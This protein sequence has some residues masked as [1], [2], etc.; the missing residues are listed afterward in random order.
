MA[1]LASSLLFV[2]YLD[3]GD[4]NL[5]GAGSGCEVVRSSGFVYFGVPYLNV[6]LVGML[7]Y[8]ILFV[9]SLGAPTVARLAR[10]RILAGIG[11][12]IALALVIAQ[13]VVIKAFCWLCG[14]VDA[15]A[16]AAAFVAVAASRAHAPQA[17]PLKPWAW[18][19]LLALVVG[20]PPLWHSVKPA[21]DVP[22]PIRELFAD[23]KINVIE[24][25][26]FQCP[27]CRRLHPT[28]KELLKEYGDK[29]NFQRL[30]MPLPN[31]RYAYDAAAAAVCAGA[32]GKGDEMADLLFE[33]HLETNYYPEYVKQLGL[34]DA[35]FT[36]CMNDPQTEA[37]ITADVERFRNSELRGLPTTFVGEQF[38]AGARP[39]EVFRE[40]FDKAAAP[41]SSFALSGWVFLGGTLAFALGLIGFGRRKNEPE[42]DEQSPVS[43]G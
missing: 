28:L 36:S 8:A 29:V 13:V 31:H 22:G 3:P 43:P 24:F 38:I 5:C 41:E 42:P 27:H 32:Q 21:P 10:A 17:Q 35:L 7:A 20:A 2:H 14:W 18:G 1:V 26:D 19:G 37:L 16:V 30:H 15:T 9:D 6:P 25:S 39:I 23:G 33:G 34:D 12:V 4:S 11:G 40:A